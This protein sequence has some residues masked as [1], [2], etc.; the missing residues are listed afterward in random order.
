MERLP[1]SKA[2]TSYH[3]R[4][5]NWEE[6][7]VSMEKGNREVHYYLK[8]KGENLDLAVIGKEKRSR[9]M[10]YRYS[11][12]NPNLTPPFKL[13]SRREVIDWLDS[14]ISGLSS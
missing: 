9:H 6:N 2:T 1:S 4:Y 13:K 8:T 10:S 7:F 11:I 14:V 5:V 3:K 12:R